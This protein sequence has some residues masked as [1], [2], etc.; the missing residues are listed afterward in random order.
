MVSDLILPE[1]RD[2]VNTG[3]GCDCSHCT[4]RVPELNVNHEAFRV[5]CLSGMVGMVGPL[6]LT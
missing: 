3:S 1:K 4:V 5:K 6:F 2:F